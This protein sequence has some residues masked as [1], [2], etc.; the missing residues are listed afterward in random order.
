MRH[1]NKKRA[2]QLMEKILS[3][4]S[5]KEAAIGDG[6]TMWQAD[7][8]V[9]GSRVDVISAGIACGC[10]DCGETVL[11]EPALSGGHLGRLLRALCGRSPA[12]QGGD[13]SLKHIHRGP[14]PFHPTTKNTQGVR[15]ADQQLLAI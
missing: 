5:A 4:M 7:D 15:S 12:R 9:I 3:L 11:H 1:L 8:F 10:H 14:T 2:R 6:Q 13:E